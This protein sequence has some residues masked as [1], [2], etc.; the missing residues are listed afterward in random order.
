MASAELVEVWP[1][2]RGSTL[3]SLKIWSPELQ[4]IDGKWYIYFALYDGIN[5]NE[6]MY[7]LE[8]LTDDAQGEYDLKGKLEIP[9]DQ[10]GY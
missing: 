9:T 4:F 1:G 8:A 10:M 7:V 2:N 5:A 6:R 3:D